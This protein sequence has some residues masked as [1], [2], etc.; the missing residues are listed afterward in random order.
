MR[1]AESKQIVWEAI[2]ALNAA[3]RTEEKPNPVFSA[4]DLEE[5]VWQARNIRLNSRVYRRYL[6]GLTLFGCLER[7]TDGALIEGQWRLV[8]DDGRVAPYINDQGKEIGYGCVYRQLWQTIRVLRRFDT[9]ELCTTSA[10]EECPVSQNVANKYVSYLKQ[11]GLLVP[12]G[13]KEAQKRQPL[14]LVPSKNTG[15]RPP[16]IETFVR[17]RD[18]NTGDVIWESADE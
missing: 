12:V 3:Q 2:R 5:Q 6:Q 14:Q 10:T 18:G 1:Y 16:V 15:P 4:A 13:K 7:I 9:L 11:A 17:V 8:R